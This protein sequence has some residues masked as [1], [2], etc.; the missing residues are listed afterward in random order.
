MTA[1][2]VTQLENVAPIAV[3]D[4]P[5]QIRW[6]LNVADR[7]QILEG[8]RFG[9]THLQYGRWGQVQVFSVPEEIHSTD[10]GLP[11][12]QLVMHSAFDVQQ[13]LEERFS[14][15]DHQGNADPKKTDKGLRV[16]FFGERDTAKMAVISDTILP[17]LT[18]IREIAEELGETS[19]IGNRCEAEDDLDFA[20]RESCPTCWAKWI[21]SP[22]CHQ[23]MEKIALTGREVEDT[24]NSE[25]WTVKPSIE[26]FRAAHTLTADSLQN[27][28]KYLQNTWGTIAREIE[29]GK[30]DGLDENGFQHS[31]RKD[32]HQ[33]KPQ[34]RQL[35]LI[36]EVAAASRGGGSDAVTERIVG[37]LDKIDQ[38]LSRLETSP[39]PS[40]TTNTT[41][42]PIT[43]QAKF[44]EGD[45]VSIDGQEG[46]IEQ[47]N[48]TLGWHR[49]KLANGDIKNLR[50]NQMTGVTKL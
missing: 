46:V 28:V 20:P 43:E 11:K 18:R 29:T 34:D 21:T 31:I 26:E 42:P 45:K 24:Q 36:Q 10:E 33:T 5:L 12:E 48:P 13:R 15:K 41:P 16:A 1:L 9:F 6:Y 14:G 4:D 30:R 44:A 27:S 39:A 32:V 49:I 22:L 50:P 25:R 3:Q 17:N 38:R 19:P 47:I 2:A 40:Q 7:E 37:V 8:F 23:Y 35:K